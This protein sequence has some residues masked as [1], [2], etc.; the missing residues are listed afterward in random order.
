MAELM[1]KK[2]DYKEFNYTGNVQSIELLPG[3]YQLECWGA[4][5]G[6]GN[7]NAYANTSWDYGK[8]GYSTGTIEI[9]TKTILYICVGGRGI[10]YSGYPAIPA[11]SLVMVDTM[12]VEIHLEIVM[13]LEVLVEEQRILHYNLDYYLL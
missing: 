9:K 5:G 2:N 8:G 7:D 13:N 6:Q 11:N 12:V 10:S 1:H 3:V 4:Q